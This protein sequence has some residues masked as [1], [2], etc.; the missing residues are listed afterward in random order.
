MTQEMPPLTLVTRETVVEV[1]ARGRLV[2]LRVG[3][4]STTIAASARGTAVAHGL[5]T[6][7]GR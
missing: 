6:I 5:S 4:L 7:A 2:P 3:L 1:L